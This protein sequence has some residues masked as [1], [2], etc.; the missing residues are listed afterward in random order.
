M[1][2]NIKKL[3]LTVIAILGLTL[4]SCDTDDGD[5]IIIVISEERAAEIVASSLAYNTYG[6][7]SN[8]SYVSNEIST[9]LNCDEQATKSGTNNYTSAFG[10]VTS[11]YQFVES[12]S[13]TCTPTEIIDYS[14]S[15][16]QDIDALY[17]TSQQDVEAGFTVTGL[18]DTSTNELYS[19]SYHREGNWFS[20]TFNDNLDIEYDMDFSDLNVDKT[21]Y[22][23]VS[24]T[25][26]F[27]MDANYSETSESTLF[28]GTVTFLNDNEA[29]I[30]FNNG[31]SYRL[32]L[33]TGKINL[34]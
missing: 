1:K 4:T 23:I 12:Y 19:G 22:Y 9:I 27:S 5:D 34:I 8:I 17:F 13:K 33:E 26:S 18:E 30:D 15:A 25:S 10:N 21:T 3:G 20:K 28:N 14:I 7:A 32:N 16:F 11:T 31:S 24:G 2:S 29:Q 6:I